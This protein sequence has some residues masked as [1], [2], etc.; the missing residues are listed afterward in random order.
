[1]ANK[2]IALISLLLVMVVGTW[3]GWRHTQ[4]LR[5][6]VIAHQ[7]FVDEFQNGIRGAS[8]AAERA[9]LRLGEAKPA[10]AAQELTG[11]DYYLQVMWLGATGMSIRLGQGLVPLGVT[12]RYQNE[13]VRLREQLLIDPSN[14]ELP[15]RLENLSHDL[16]LLVE[17]L[18]ADDQREWLANA[19]ADEF[20]SRYQS[21]REKAMIKLEVP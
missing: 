3:F 16:T 17:L 8:N 13:A 20:S 4:L 11:S 9:Q 1:M 14:P 19:T 2:P 21:W 7:Q 10:L 15:Q 18:G 12:T 5:Y 6:Q